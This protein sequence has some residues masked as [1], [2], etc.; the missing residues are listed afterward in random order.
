[1][2]DC[3]LYLPV[4]D[5]LKVMTRRLTMMNPT[6][7]VK[8]KQQSLQLE[9]R[10]MTI[11]EQSEIIEAADEQN[12]IFYIFFY[13]KKYLN[14][15]TSD[16][17]TKR[18]YVTE[19]FDKGVTLHP[20]H[21]LI[22]TVVSPYPYFEKQDFDD[23]LKKVKQ[24]Y[25]FQEAVLIATFFESF[26]KKDDLA[27]FMESI[28]YKER[29]DGKLLSCYRI[30]RILKGFVPS[31]HLI[32]AFAGNLKF[33]QY[34]DRYNEGDE[35]LLAMDPI[36]VEH[37]FYA[38]QHNDL[39]FQKLIAFYKEQS[40]WVDVIAIL[41]AR[42]ID[43]KDAD[44]YDALRLVTDEH[45]GGL[46]AL[47]V[48][49]D[50]F[51]R[52]LET[53]SLKEDLLDAYM[54]VGRLEDAL[55]LISKHEL[56]LQQSQSQQLVGI[57]KNKGITVDSI[58]HEGLQTLTRSL[59]ASKEGQASEVLYQA[60][61]SMLKEHDITY[62]QEWLQP[63]KDIPLARPTVQRIDEMN[64]IVEEPNQQQRLGELYHYFHQPRKA[65][66]CMSWDMELREDDPEP[67]QWLAKLYD[68]LGMDEEHKAYRQLY[69]NMVK[70][71]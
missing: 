63:F 65:I 67:V 35:T 23:L 16:K 69:M 57:V 24:K 28:F 21:P 4:S 9:I 56:S 46:K 10:R 41:I 13:K 44:D 29:R 37:R 47:H 27:D 71:A 15:G 59:F 48:L 54:E 30:L 34:E 19:T 50:L 1:M 58:P 20:P 64:Q 53:K 6:L 12:Q 14:Y 39:S 70:H 49:E 22:E 60:V 7:H 52:G 33:N 38:Y 3:Y 45:Y 51:E 40:R 8:D 2:T 18:S 55:K 11:Y 5:M 42:V 68:E 43:T 25:T 61:V 31:H 36:F 26:V 66:D 32:S 62:T 17:I